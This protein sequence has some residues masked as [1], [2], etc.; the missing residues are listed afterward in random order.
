MIKAFSDQ[1]AALTGGFAKVEKTMKFL[2][3][4]KLFMY[5]RFHSTVKGD[6]DSVRLSVEELHI[7]MTTKMT[8]IQIGLMEIMESLL[9]EIVKA[10]SSVLPNIRDV[11]Y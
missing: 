9:N 1:A 11:P 7:G 3:V 4:P 5:P 10:N 6:L 8:T 2:K